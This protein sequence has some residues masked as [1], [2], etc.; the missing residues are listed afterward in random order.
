MVKRRF[1]KFSLRSQF[2]MD[3]NSPICEGVKY[4]NLTRV[5]FGTFSYSRRY[6]HGQ[7]HILST[8][9]AVFKIHR[10]LVLKFYFVMLKTRPPA[11]TCWGKDQSLNSQGPP[12]GNACKV[13]TFSYLFVGSS[14]IHLTQ[15]SK[16]IYCCIII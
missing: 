12:Y 5:R 11:I 6:N 7:S 13:Y 4:L 1:E 14:S 16:G 15:L 2:D 9:M 8:L 3:Q 10:L